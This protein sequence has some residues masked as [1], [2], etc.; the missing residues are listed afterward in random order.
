MT[1]ILLSVGINTDRILYEDEHLLAVNKLPSELVVAAEGEGKLPL[2]DF[3][4]KSYPGLRVLHRL[5]FG[6]SGVVLFARTKEAA[7]KV[8]D[9]KF[10][11]WTKTYRAL[12][13]GYVQQKTGTIDRKL[14]AR[15]QDVDVPAVTRYR[16]LR[17]FPE[18]T[19]VE[20]VIETGRK[21]QIRQHFA[22]IGHPLVLDPL[23]GD[24]K[25]DKGFAKRVPYRKFFL[26]A[27]RLELPHP[28]TGKMLSIQAPLPQAFEK[29][30]DILA[31]R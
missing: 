11:G 23:Y 20:A 2:F 28:I 17:G 22:A 13:A 29:A 4:K 19:F 31:G 24:R 30:I 26:H 5:D 6:T 9:S 1:G 12:V 14:P 3:L 7:E 27:Y 21:H 18:A 8:K 16:V 25:K 15:E 10:E